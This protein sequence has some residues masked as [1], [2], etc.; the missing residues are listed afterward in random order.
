MVHMPSHIDVRVG[1]WQRAI[2]ANEKAIHAD[3]A[4]RA[5]SP[6]QD[7]FRTYMAHNH[8]MLTIAAMM[9]GQNRRST[10]AIHQMLEEIPDSW[11]EQNAVF[12][13]GMFAMPYEVHIRFGR[14]D[15][16][17]VAPEPREMLPVARAFR[18]YA[19]GVAYAA[20]EQVNEARAEQR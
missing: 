9:R 6:D 2:D 15:E 14:W 17:L 8:H 19:S 3:A 4:Y 16:I 1:Q 12:V 7:F 5:L 11:L 10:D 13:D 20:K 18:H